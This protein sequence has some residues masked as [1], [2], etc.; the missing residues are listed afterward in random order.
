[1]AEPSFAFPDDDE[2]SGSI[3]VLPGNGLL[4]FSGMVGRTSLRRKGRLGVFEKG[5]DFA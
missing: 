1:M 2:G 4:R 3:L 5:P